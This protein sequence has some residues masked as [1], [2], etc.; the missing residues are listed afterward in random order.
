[1]RLENLDAGG[2]I[3]QYNR[4][5]TKLILDYMNLVNI[6][7]AKQK[8]IVEDILDQ[9][10]KIMANMTPADVTPVEKGNLK[11]SSRANYKDN[12]IL[13]GDIEADGMDGSIFVDYQR[14]V[15]FGTENENGSVKMEARP[16]HIWTT[17]ELLRYI[18][19][20]YKQ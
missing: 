17:F 12:Q 11:N 19:N 4:H 14:F 9:G 3:A 16:Y 8:I 18:Q 6:F 20:K 1:L 5:L 10:V 2:H 15:A 13:S 7:K